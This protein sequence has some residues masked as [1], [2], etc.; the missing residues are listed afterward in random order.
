MSFDLF[1]YGEDLSLSKRE[2][3]E[4]NLRGHMGDA[5][6]E[7]QWHPEFDM[8]VPFRSATIPFKLR[9]KADAVPEANHYGEEPLLAYLNISQGKNN[10]FAALKEVPWRHK[11]KVLGSSTQ[12]M[13][14]TA[15]G[16]DP[17]SFRLQATFA[18]ILCLGL[19]GV[20]LD[21]QSKASWFNP[22]EACAHLFLQARAFD[23]D[24]AEENPG[25]WDIPRFEKWPD[26]EVTRT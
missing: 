3:V 10:R 1:V 25:L 5:G 8:T 2:D 14:T 13:F 15:A 18:A 26:F 6:L 23:M 19:K 11:G 9:V 16:R 12:Y 4:S 22:R 24:H 17:L 20:L 21:P 7:T